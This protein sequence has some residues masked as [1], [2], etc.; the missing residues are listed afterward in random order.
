M[1]RSSARIILAVLGISASVLPARAEELA[2]AVGQRGNWDTSITQLGEQ[3]G[4]F[5]KHGLELK[6]LYTHGGAETQQAVLSRGVDIGVAVGTL[7]ALGVASKGA[8]L[9]IIGGEA[10]GVGELYWYVPLASSIKTIADLP[11]HTIG[12]STIGSSSHTPL[13]LL[14][15]ERNLD[16]NLVATGG[17]PDT[18]TQTMSGQIDV[19]WAAAPFGLDQVDKSIRI[20]A[21]GGDIAGIRNQTSRVLITHAAVLAAKKAAI[22]KFLAAYRE[23]IEWMYEGDQSIAAFSAFAG[24]SEAAAKRTRDEFFPKAALDPGTLTGLADMMADGVQFKFLQ[25][26]LT[27]DQLAQIVQIERNM[28]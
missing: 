3:A 11:G 12:F 20:V 9:R 27:Q 23:T 17:P 13:L 28:P 5:K 14:A 18:F 1:I 21:R 22:D 10:T 24:V 4:I 2:V 16:L 26:P 19:G 7:G 25:A 6:L 8:P 15:R